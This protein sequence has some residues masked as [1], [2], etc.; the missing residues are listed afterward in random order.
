MRKCANKSTYMRG[1]LVIYD[2]QLLHSEFPYIER[3]FP[4]L[5]YQCDGRTPGVRPGA[6]YGSRSHL[7]AVTV[8]FV[9]IFRWTRCQ[10]GREV[11]PR[12]YIYPSLFTLYFSHNVLFT[13]LARQ[14][15]S[16][17]YCNCL[18]N[19]A[20]PLPR[21]VR[22]S[23]VR[24]LLF[25]HITCRNYVK[26]IIKIL[27][28]YLFFLYSHYWIVYKSCLVGSSAVHIATLPWQIHC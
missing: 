17:V 18:I 22:C 19:N 12:C 6:L 15:S 20:I 23:F 24:R 7:A 27:N 28:I 5:F 25:S 13:N 11:L 2:L 3:K 4:F 10:P 14:S 21:K 1:Q 8:G 16:V 9:E 26:N